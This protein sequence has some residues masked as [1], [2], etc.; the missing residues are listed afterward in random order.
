MSYRNLSIWKNIDKPLL[1][2]YFLLTVIGYL[3]M[4][5]STY[6]GLNIEDIFWVSNYGKQLTW[7]IITFFL[8][9]FILL[10]DG[11]FIKN[12]AYFT[13]GIVLLLLIIVLFMPP[14][15]GARSWFY[16]NSFSIQP[17]EFIKLT[18]SLALAKLLSDV[19]SKF[20]DFKTKLKAFLLIIIPALLISIQPDPGTMLVFT[21]FVFV[22]YREGLSGNFLLIGFFTVLIAVVGIFLKASNSVFFIGNTSISGN[23]FFGI[24]LFVGF[25]FSFLIIR[26]FVLPR[27]RKQKIKRLI[28]ISVLGLSISGGIN[29]VYDSVFSERHRTRFQIMFGIKEDR[30]G[31]GYNI[32]QALSAVG[33]G[34]SFGKGYLKGTLSNDKYKHVPEQNTDFI[35]CVLAEEWGFFGS[36]LFISLY[37]SSLIRIIIIAERQRSKFTRI[38]GYCVSA[39]L[40]F[41]FMINIAMV[42][43]LAPVIGIPLPFFSKGGSA[44]LSFGLMIF[45]LLRL[46]SERKVVLR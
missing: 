36:I 44:I 23:V 21:C 18:L 33:S 6:K 3:I 25:L 43:G 17:S 37:L 11:S 2:T 31:A 35:F 9:F 20:Q 16:F 42:I 10:L 45:I 41:H 27:Y 32:Y 40:F 34:E 46:D 39:I 1:V 12:T 19:G 13:Y 4:Y 24:I 5:S 14:I 8:G 15:K 29:Y 22:L 30:K 26:Y 38:Y 7:I 28:I